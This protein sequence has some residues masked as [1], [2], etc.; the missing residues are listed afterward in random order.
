LENPAISFTQATS[1]TAKLTVKDASGCASTLTKN[2]VFAISNN[3][4]TNFT[5]AI[6]PGEC[7]PIKS[8]SVANF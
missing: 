8:T 1:Y 5:Y 4:I 3:Y 6:E 2:N 7:S